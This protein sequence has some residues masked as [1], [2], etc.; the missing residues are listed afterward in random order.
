[1]RRMPRGGTLPK[2]RPLMPLFGTHVS[3]AGGLCNAFGEFRE[4]GGQAFQIFT[5]NQRRWESAPL[6]VEEAEN[7]R[8]LWAENGR[9]P[10][11][12]HGSYLLNLA[13]GDPE[14][15]EKTVK[16]LVDELKRVE[17]L[18]IPYIVLHPGSHGGDGV[19]VG[20]ARIA[21]NIAIAF[22][23]AQSERATVLLETTS[24]AGNSVG[25]L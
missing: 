2:G 23:E 14:I 13:S 9:P 21:E 16:N 20:I 12:S 10:I 18:H 17:M 24:G 15:S 22:E 4:V 8:A 25:G 3:V 7:F 5:K 6:A 19:E 1:M 11:A